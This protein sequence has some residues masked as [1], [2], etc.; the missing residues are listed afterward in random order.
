MTIPPLRERLVDLPLIAEHILAREAAA[1][2]GRRVQLS[3]EVVSALV[4]HP[5]PGNI[6][7]LQ[8]ALQFAFLKCKGEVIGLEHLPPGMRKIRAAEVVPRRTAQTLTDEAIAE[9]L[10]LTG[11]N[12]TRA[13]EL[14]GVSRATFYRHLGNGTTK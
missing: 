6:R 11:G 7:E 9:A 10:Q 13:A 3:D 12:R 2:G 1:A 14:L 4:A 5:W 8:N